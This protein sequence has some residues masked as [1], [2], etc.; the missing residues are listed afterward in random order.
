MSVKHKKIYIM[1]AD[2]QPSS[3]G[4]D[5]VRQS[6]QYLANNDVFFNM[7]WTQARSDRPEFQEGTQRINNR[8]EPFDTTVANFRAWLKQEG[9]AINEKR[10]DSYFFHRAV[11]SPTDPGWQRY[12]LVYYHLSDTPAGSGWLKEYSNLLVEYTLAIRQHE[13]T[14]AKQLL[15][16]AVPCSACEKIVDPVLRATFSRKGYLACPY[17][18]QWWT[19]PLEQE[20]AAESQPE[21]EVDV[22]S[23]P[24]PEPV[25]KSQPDP[26]PAV[27]PRPKKKWWQFRK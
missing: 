25:A 26:E 2:R 19:K 13:Q 16:S 4:E 23:G 8:D 18:G 10:W 5:F 9:V 7:L 20:P 17:C 15:G 11:P 14:K 21:L 22:S 27:E 3:V 24:E 6:L 12:A 1:V